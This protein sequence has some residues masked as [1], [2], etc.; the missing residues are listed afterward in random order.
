VTFEI[1]CRYYKDK[2]K[3]GGPAKLKKVCIQR[4]TRKAIGMYVLQYALQ[5][6]WQFF[7]QCV[8]VC[9]SVLQCV[10]VYGCAKLKKVCIQRRARKAAGVYCCNVS[11]SV[12]CTVSC[13]VSCHA[14]SQCVVAVCVA[15][16]V[17]VAVCLGRLY[18]YNPLS[19][20]THT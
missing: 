17:T 4:R 3:F 11:C 16:C 18:L 8:A 14:L 13:N 6:V 2:K 9:C 12:Y 20:V 5:C 1:S 7:S 10:A 19:H 15:M